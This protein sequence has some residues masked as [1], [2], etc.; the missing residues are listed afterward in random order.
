VFDAVA[1]VSPTSPLDFDRRVKA[2]M[3]FNKLPEAES[4]AAANKRINNILKKNP[5]ADGSSVNDALFEKAEENAL[6]DKLGQIKGDVE[7]YFSKGDYTPALQALSSMREPVDNFFDEVM[8]M[9]D[10]TA[11]KNNRLA[12]LG[13]LHGLFT[14]VANLGD[15]QS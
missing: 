10:D 8:V 5:V 4:L 6:F 3:E 2:V 1:S 7:G 15:L 14:H 13:E 9:A 11:V 12:L